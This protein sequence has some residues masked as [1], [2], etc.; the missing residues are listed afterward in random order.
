MF[1]CIASSSCRW[2]ALIFNHRR[3]QHLVLVLSCGTA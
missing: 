3:L 1:I 2:L